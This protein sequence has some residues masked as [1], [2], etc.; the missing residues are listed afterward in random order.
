MEKL[1]FVDVE[2]TGVDEHIHEPHQISL[3]VVI[4]GKLVEVHTLYARPI[5][6]DTISSEALEKCNVTLET[7]KT[8][9]LY[10]S[11]SP[12]DRTRSRMPS[13]A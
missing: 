1:L 3:M 4:S 10:T 12:R 8:C 2:T 13:S 9:L 5:N 6:W 11:P 7:L